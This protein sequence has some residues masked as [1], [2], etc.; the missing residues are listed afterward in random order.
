MELKRPGTRLTEADKQQGLSYARMLHPR[1]P[2]VVVTNGIDTRFYEVHSGSLW[3]PADP[4]EREVQSLFTAASEIAAADMKRAMEVLLGPTSDVW[5]QAVRSSSNELISDM[6]GSMEDSLQPFAQ[7]FLIPRLATTAA[8]AALETSKLV[9]IEGAPQLGKSN[10][11]REMVAKMASDKTFAALYLE[12]EPDGP[13][14]LQQLANVLSGTL[15]WGVGPTEVRQWLQKLSLSPGPSL[16]ILL[17]GVGADRDEIYRDL[18]ELI[19][20]LGVKLKVVIAMDDNVAD[21]LV[22]NA[23][24]RKASLLG[25]TA[26]RV[27]LDPLSD[28]EFDVAMGVLSDLKIGIMLGGRE[29]DEYRYPWV[30]RTAIAG[31]S[32][33]S[34]QLPDGVMRLIPSLLGTSVIRYARDLFP[35]QPELRRQFQ[36][37]ARAILTDVQS[38]GRTAETI[39]LSLLLFLVPRGAVEAT[40]ERQDIDS[41]MAQGAL[42]QTIDGTGASMFVV[43]MPELLA[44]ALAIELANHIVDELS[45]QINPAPFISG[46]SHL[47]PFGDVIAAQAIIDA[48]QRIDTLPMSVLEW[49]LEHGP[50]KTPVRSGMKGLLLHPEAGPVDLTFSAESETRGL[51]MSVRLHIIKKTSAV[52]MKW[53]IGS[54]SRKLLLSQ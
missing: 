28:E 41:L 2:L 35:N 39:L 15:H 30:L 11:L 49:L 17:D 16:V 52:C 48:A 43:R 20:G 22:V 12:G 27:K 29:S 47:L 38:A 21:R 26:K 14:I 53:R 6:T 54:F 23:T 18:N 8:L 4:S 24:G 51:P 3:E 44:S 33:G 7:D 37:I 25:R 5:V 13:G 40:L 19:S 36:G 45:M 1:P 9:I 34:D 46:V 42:R 32:T 31:A 10:V 50:T